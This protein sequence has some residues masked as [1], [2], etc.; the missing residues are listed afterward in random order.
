MGEFI[1]VA[2]YIAFLSI[3]VLTAL[4][5]IGAIMQWKPFQNVDPTHTKWLMGVLLGELAGAVI[6][7]YQNL[8]EPDWKGTEP[9]QLKLTYIN[10]LDDYKKSLSAFDKGCLDLHKEGYTPIS[11]KSAVENY[12]KLKSV[13][14]DIGRGELYLDT[15]SG[16]ERE[17][18]A[19][20]LF[21]GE[22]SRIV[23]EVSGHTY[24]DD[25]IELDFI[26]PPRYVST[27][28]GIQKRKGHKFKI[29]FTRDQQ[30]DEIYKGTL[31][32]PT[33]KVEGKPLALAEAILVK[34]R[35]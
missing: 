15:G 17:G 35:S 29:S 13:I 14:G 12:T 20:Y 3:F 28:E 9:Y 30:N 23:M 24:S 31:D 4:V 10:Y 34:K 8:P 32:H 33:L 18:Q 19:I 6:L 1:I 7:T 21:P 2:F 26:Q 25:E 22:D 16:V 5:A 27:N 11:C